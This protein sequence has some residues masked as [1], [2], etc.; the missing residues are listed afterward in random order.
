MLPREKNLESWGRLS[1]LPHSVIEPAFQGRISQNLSAYRENDKLAIGSQLSYGDV[2]MNSH[3]LTI[4]TK[5]LDR[6]LQVDWSLGIMRAEA[7]ITFDQILKICVPRGWFLPVTPGT[8]FVTLGGAVAN[9]VHGKNHDFVGSFGCHVR[10]IGLA[11]STGEFLELSPDSNSELFSATIAG[12]G[13]TGM[14]IWVEFSLQRMESSFLE[15]Q[16]IRMRSLEDF[17]RI[18]EE[19][20]CWEH[21]IAW[22]DCLAK[23]RDFGR[24]VFM[25]GRH[26]HNAP[27]LLHSSPR[28]RV[29][30][31][32][33]FNFFNS[34]NT[35]IFNSIF[36]SCNV[37]QH[38]KVSHYNKFFYPLDSLGNW[39]QLYGPS[40]FYQHQSVIPKRYAEKGI[41]D[42]LK[43]TSSMAQGS[44]FAALKNFGAIRSPGL[45]SF[46]M[47][48]TTFGIDIS[49]MGAE[50]LRLLSLMNEVVGSY[51]G[52][53][54]PAKD[55]VML[56]SHFKRFYP[57]WSQFQKLRDPGFNSNFWRRVVGDNG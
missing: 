43:L 37:F 52:R 10:K 47:Q 13:L 49:N 7:G 24:G 6:I 45:L 8:K 4:S 9:D 15:T 23:G 36:W 53:V 38:T 14:I 40:G 33:P 55:A 27:L 20:K 34:K 29:P 12:L 50:S 41:E 56:P 5:S 3:G 25:R 57:N 17:F 51:G 32:F 42:L 31:K 30:N 35:R 48:G 16:S 26:L 18:S 28:L 11:L 54:Y 22:V 44:F 2:G 39:N 21:T 19:S 1:R 46:P